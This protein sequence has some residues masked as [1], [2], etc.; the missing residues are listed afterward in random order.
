[1]GNNASLPNELNVFHAHI[2]QK[3]PQGRIFSPLLYSLYTHDCVSKFHPNTICKFA[4]DTTVVGQ[5]SNNHETEYRKEKEYLKAWCK[6]NNHFNISKLKELVIDFR[7][8]SGGHTPICIN[9][10]EVE[11]T[12]SVKFLGVMIT[13]NLSWSTR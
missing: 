5:I 10:A 2:K 7:K 11:M 8:Q 4:D 6:D 3:C 13:N 1:M 12:E 9:G